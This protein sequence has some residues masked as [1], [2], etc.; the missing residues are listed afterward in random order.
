MLYLSHVFD[1]CSCGKPVTTEEEA[2]ASV[3]EYYGKTI[4]K[5]SDLKTSCCTLGAPLNR[6]IKECLTAVPDEILSKYELYFFIAISYKTGIYMGE[7][8]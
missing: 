8:K 6:T 1:H 4:Q 5:T 3:Q 7:D 2:H